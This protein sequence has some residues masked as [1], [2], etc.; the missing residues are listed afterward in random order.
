MCMRSWM[1]G[2]LSILC[3]CSIPK[4]EILV[5]CVIFGIFDLLK[6]I[7]NEEMGKG[8]LYDR[9]SPNY[10]AVIMARPK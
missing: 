7:E 3:H 4:L 1:L 6:T 8:W 9:S 10:A 2:N 5:N